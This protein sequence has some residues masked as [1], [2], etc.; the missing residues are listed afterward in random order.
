MTAETA[1]IQMTIFCE[2]LPSRFVCITCQKTKNTAKKLHAFI[3]GT[4]QGKSTLL[5]LVP[6]CSDCA[7]EK[8]RKNA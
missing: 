4:Q 1:K 2:N 5:A 3:N 7:A 8:E 6:E